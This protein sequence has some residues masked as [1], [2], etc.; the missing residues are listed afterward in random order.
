MGK[1]DKNIIQ[2]ID[3]KNRVYYNLITSLNDKRFIKIGAL[4]LS[5]AHRFIVI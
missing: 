2:I 5:C 1:T 4:Q 3:K